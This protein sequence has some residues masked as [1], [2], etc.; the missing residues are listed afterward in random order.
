MV[1]VLLV[2]IAA[3]GFAAW[4]LG[5][6]MISLHIPVVYM[7]YPDMDCV[8]V[9][10]GESD[11]NCDNMPPRFTVVYVDPRWAGFSDEGE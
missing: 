8:T 2:G 4:L 1:K 5:S 6:L 9:Q 10:G 11:E 7:T 3:V